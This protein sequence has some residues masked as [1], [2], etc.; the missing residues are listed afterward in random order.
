MNSSK[1]C[2]DRNGHSWLRYL[3]CYGPD[4]ELYGSGSSP[5]FH[6]RAQGCAGFWSWC[7]V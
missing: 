4:P 3:G 2:P 5:H 6:P 1:L 7:I